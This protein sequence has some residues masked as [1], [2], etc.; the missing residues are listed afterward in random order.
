MHV[1]R[2]GGTN[3]WHSA[4]HSWGSE[5]GD[6]GFIDLHHEA[7]TRLRDPSAEPE[8]IQTILP[9]FLSDDKDLFIHHHTRARL[10]RIFGDAVDYMVLLRDPVE[11]YLSHYCYSMNFYFEIDPATSQCRL[12]DV[13]RSTYSVE[14][15][16]RKMAFP[17]TGSLY[18]SILQAALPPDYFFDAFLTVRSKHD[19]CSPEAISLFLDLNPVLCDYYTRY[20]AGYF[21]C[22][23]GRE[24]P[25]IHPEIVNAGTIDVL[26]S[27][28]HQH[29]DAILWS[30]EEAKSHLEG[31]FGRE[32]TKRNEFRNA[33]FR[34]F[35]VTD[36]LRASL[37]ARF[38]LDYEL[39]DR[40]K[41]QAADAPGP[42]VGER[43]GGGRE[44]GARV[45]VPNG[46][47]QDAK[48]AL[49]RMNREARRFQEALAAER[50]E[51]EAAVAALNTAKAH[52]DAEIATLAAA[53]SELAALAEISEQQEKEIAR[54]NLRLE[55]I[56]ASRSWR[57]AAP[58]RRIST[59]ARSI[60]GR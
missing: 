17:E 35:T 40:L 25:V 6:I 18:N 4:A 50:A 8:A 47:K 14:Q 23:D 19:L 31:Y 36:E 33:A 7:L 56:Y 2:T 15:I 44:D 30:P 21:G 3:V 42:D 5:T 11:R 38:T 54:L 28:M 16:L 43:E 57:V 37:R 52:V 48:N 39:I 12:R 53:N 51:R 32:M 45:Q 59:I 1:P 26:A 24:N 13:A 55:A 22:H 41:R 46:S 34:P 58:L 10:W 49:A 20:F 60:G 27:L 9:Y 29:Y